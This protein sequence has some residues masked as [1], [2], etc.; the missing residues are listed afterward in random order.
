MNFSYYA[1]GFWRIWFISFV[2]A[3]WWIGSVW[4]VADYTDLSTH[5]GVLRRDLDIF[6]LC[7]FT[8]LFLN[9]WML[10]SDGCL[11]DF[12]GQEEEEKTGGRI[13]LFRCQHSTPSFLYFSFLFRRFWNIILSLTFEFQF[14]WTF[15]PIQK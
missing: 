15:I 5:F 13:F 12:E 7:F 10:K 6:F 11:P 1:F 9:F 14:T 4:I 2:F 3:W 8:K